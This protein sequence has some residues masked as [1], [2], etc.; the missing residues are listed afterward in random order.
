MTGGCARTTQSI[1]PY[2]TVLIPS[3]P[4]E[5]KGDRVCLAF[6]LHQHPHQGHSSTT[7]SPN[8]IVR[9]CLET[10]SVSEVSPSK[11]GSGCVTD[12]TEALPNPTVPR[13]GHPPPKVW[14][15]HMYSEYP[16]RGAPA[17]PA[18]IDLLS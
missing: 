8:G 5:K 13:R 9:R 6:I 17:R 10:G 18:N 12:V 16:Q 7:G 4:K 15:M 11:S 1:K 3:P 14:D 2:M